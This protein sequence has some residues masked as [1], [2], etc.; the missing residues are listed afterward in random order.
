M[1]EDVWQTIVEAVS[2][3][4]HM[5]TAAALAGVSPSTLRQWLRDGKR[6]KSERL[7]Q[8][9]AE[10]KKAQAEAVIGDLKVIEA[11][12]HA[13]WQARAWRLERRYPRLWGRDRLELL[14]MRKKLAELEKLIRGTETCQ[15]A[16]AGGEAPG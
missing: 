1:T 14:E 8:F 5:E 2:H 7:A 3:S 6:G 12:G 15:S 10:V 4:C 13:Y 9:S 11:A 16:P